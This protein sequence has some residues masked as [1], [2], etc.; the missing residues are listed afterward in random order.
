MSQIC[1]REP[2]NVASS[3]KLMD[4]ANSKHEGKSLIYEK[5][6]DPTRFLA[7]LQTLKHV[8]LNYEFWIVHTV[9][10]SL[11]KLKT[12]LME[13]LLFPRIK[14]SDKSHFRI[15][16]KTRLLLYLTKRCTWMCHASGFCYSG[17]KTFSY[18]KKNLN[19]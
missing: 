12:I 14:W 9:F 13:V 7:V 6:A 11:S 8:C 3:E 1:V 16:E 17:Y 10:Y 19:L 2:D 18:W 15:L 5:G 4:V